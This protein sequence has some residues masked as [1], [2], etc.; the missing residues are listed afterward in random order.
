MFDIPY[1]FTASF[2]APSPKPLFCVFESGG[3]AISGVKEMVLSNKKLKLKLRAELLSQQQNNASEIP[4]SSNSLKTLLDAATPTPRLSKREKRR[5]L[6]P[7]NPPEEPNKVNETQGSN[8]KKRKRKIEDDDVANEV[9]DKSKNK[10]KKQKQKNKNKNKNKKA[11][12]V[13]EKDSNGGGV[14][15]EATELSKTNTNARY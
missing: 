3:A 15:A 11:E 7:S 13:E 2:V 12:T 10:K 6:R 9:S 5:N 14:I 1:E 8:K 4:S